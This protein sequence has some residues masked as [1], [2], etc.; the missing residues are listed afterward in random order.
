MRPDWEG[1]RQ[2]EDPRVRRP[3]GRASLQS[4]SRQ[5]GAAMRQMTVLVAVALLMACLP[6]DAEEPPR[7]LDP[8]VVT[9]TTVATPA[10]QLG[11]SVTV[12][13]GEEFQTKHYPSVDEA[14]RKVPGVE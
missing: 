3:V 11:A 13:D 1:G 2:G 6:V 4:F 10:S 12:I 7:K 5:E 14:L 8:V 9:A